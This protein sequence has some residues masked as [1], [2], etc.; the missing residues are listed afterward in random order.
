MNFVDPTRESFDAFK[1][2]PRDTPINM[3]NLVRLNDLADYP[4]G[5]PHDGKGWTG[6]QAYAEY[7]RSSGTIFAK[8]GGTVIWRGVQ[9][10]ILTGPQDE[11]WDL[12]FIARYPNASAFLEMITDPKYR[13]S[14]VNRQAAVLTSRLVRFAPA[15][16]SHDSFG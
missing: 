11:I 14:V 8:V 12:C 7:G 15:E 1:G 9:E 6:A 2:L 3:L 10:S 4:T 13:L 5:H 16:G